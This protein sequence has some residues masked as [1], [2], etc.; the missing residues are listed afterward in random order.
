MEFET[1]RL[2][3]R[4]IK[5]EDKSDFYDIMGNNKTMQFLGNVLTHEEIDGFI[6]SVSNIDH[7]DISGEYAIILKEENKVIGMFAIK[8][9]KRD[10]KAEISYMLNSDYWKM[11]YAT[12]I[13]KKVMDTL[14]IDENFNKIVADCDSNNLGSTS[15][16]TKLGMRQEGILKEERFSK[17]FNNYYDVTVFGI[18]SKDY[19][20]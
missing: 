8:T 17:L 13:T 14:F 10:K 19:E 2:F 18:L 12:E 7:N 11:G 4:R 15:L 16:L 1:D 3:L 5:K 20:K 6:D 9:K